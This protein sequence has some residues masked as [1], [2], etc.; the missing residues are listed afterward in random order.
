MA[1]VHSVHAPP[2][3]LTSV[4]VF[5]GLLRLLGRLKLHVGV[6]FGQVRVDAV[7]GHVNHLDLAIDGEDLLDVFLQRHKAEN[8]LTLATTSRHIY[9]KGMQVKHISAPLN[10][11]NL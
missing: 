8:V 9:I 6:A 11:G 4:H 5:Q 2:R 3:P 1:V 10:E 7:R